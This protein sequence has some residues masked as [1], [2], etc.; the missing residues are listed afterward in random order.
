MRAMSAANRGYLIRCAHLDSEDKA[1]GNAKQFRWMQGEFTGRSASGVEHADRADSPIEPP[2]R[3]R[4][5]RLGP[6]QQPRGNTTSRAGRRP[7]HHLRHADRVVKK[8]RIPRGDAARHP[9]AVKATTEGQPGR[10]ADLHPP[11]RWARRVAS[12]RCARSPRS[13]TSL[14]ARSR[15]TRPVHLRCLDRPQAGPRPRQR[16]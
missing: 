15:P 12:R 10:F 4:R 16:R 6:R 5:V 1:H 9:R 13:S 11:T 8:L 14:R 2:A 3:L 7:A